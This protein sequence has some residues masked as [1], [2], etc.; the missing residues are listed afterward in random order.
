MT[1]VIQLTIPEHSHDH[2]VHVRGKA[3]GDVNVGRVDHS[4]S[5]TLNAV[6]SAE[7]LSLWPREC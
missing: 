7:P 4:H 5:T 3:H 2:S 1:R 6:N